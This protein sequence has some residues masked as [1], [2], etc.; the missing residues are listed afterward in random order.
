M[1]SHSFLFRILYPDY[2]MG[3]EVVERNSVHQGRGGG[4]TG[5]RRVPPVAVMPASYKRLL[6]RGKI[7]THSPLSFGIETTYLMDHR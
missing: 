7:S 1:R 6:M 2:W 3:I 4:A 5:K